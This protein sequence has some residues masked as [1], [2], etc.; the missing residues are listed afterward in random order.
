M[1][2]SSHLQVPWP[3]GKTREALECEWDDWLCFPL[4]LRHGEG[5]SENEAAVLA[6]CR[7]LQPNSVMKVVLL[8]GV[9]LL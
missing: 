3:V 1:G 8:L 4:F 5:G 6:A 9:S 7:G 2:G